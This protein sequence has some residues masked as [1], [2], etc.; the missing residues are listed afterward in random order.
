VPAP[1]FLRLDF[2]MNYIKINIL[3][4][5]HLWLHIIRIRKLSILNGS[6]SF[7]VFK[8]TGAIL[9]QW[10]ALMQQKDHFVEQIK[11]TKL[12]NI[13][14]RRPKSLCSCWLLIKKGAIKLLKYFI[15]DDHFK[16]IWQIISTTIFNTWGEVYCLVHA[17]YSLKLQL[18][19]NGWA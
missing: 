13:C 3:K 8:L 4:K 1:P 7:I 9:E 14:R 12:T 5:R 15:D 18:K 11:M 2:F 16:A 17:I 10:I 6:N 19:W